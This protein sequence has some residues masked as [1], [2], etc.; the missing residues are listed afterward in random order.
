MTTVDSRATTGAPSAS[1]A[2][3]L[4]ETR[5]SDEGSSDRRHI[6]TRRLCR[7]QIGASNVRRR[8]RAHTWRESALQDASGGARSGSGDIR[9]AARA[10]AI[11]RIKK[12]LSGV[13][14]QNGSDANYFSFFFS[15]FCCARALC[16][17]DR[18][19][20]AAAAAISKRR[21]YLVA[22]SVTLMSSE[23]FCKSNFKCE[24]LLQNFRLVIRSFFFQSLPMRRAID[25][26][27]P[28]KASMSSLKRNEN[29]GGQES[30]NLRVQNKQT[31]Q[32]PYE[33]VT[34]RLPFITA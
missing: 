8:R 32:Q 23:R 2:R 29:G 27:L 11:I 34:R 17:L 7:G 1:A 10:R 9:D 16:F 24:L 28:C 5:T 12:S 14:L 15:P 21:S 18:R 20:K 31:K 30:Y 33:R 25:I 3:T 6:K 19:E 22:T 13:W 4:A 26:C